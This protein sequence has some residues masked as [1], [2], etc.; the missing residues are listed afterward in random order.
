LEGKLRIG[1]AER[2]VLVAVAQ[3][4]VLA[5]REKGP[6]LNES[7]KYHFVYIASSRQPV[8]NGVKKNWQAGLKRLLKL[9]KQSIGVKILVFV[10][11]LPVYIHFK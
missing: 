2:S 8:K 4:V 5:E 6:F 3:A 9:S 11:M 1:N 7:M 10:C